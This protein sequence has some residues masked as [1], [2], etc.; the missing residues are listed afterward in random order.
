MFEL[1]VL[2]IAL[3]I[4]AAAAAASIGASQPSWRPVILGAL[5]FGLFQAAMSALGCWGGSWLAARAG[6]V[7]HWIAFVLLTGIGLRAIVGALR[8]GEDAVR[9]EA[10]V[11]TLLTLA[12]ATSIDALAA[13][14]TLPLLPVHWLLAVS[15]IGGVTAALSMLGGALGHKLGAELGPAVEIGGG[16]VLIGL[17][18]KILAEHLGWLG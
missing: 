14:V 4:D 17:G 6:A 9:S 12:V 3:A 10:G 16:L 1:V 5:L 15:V 11:L 13:G 18:T 8:G 2:A 7:D